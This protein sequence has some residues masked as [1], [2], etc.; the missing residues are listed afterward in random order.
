VRVTEKPHLTPQ[1]PGIGAA[2]EPARARIDSRAMMEGGAFILLKVGC[3]GPE[4]AKQA[5]IRLAILLK[6]L[7]N[8]PF[9]CQKWLARAGQDVPGLYFSEF[10]STWLI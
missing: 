9:Q 10:L 3:K 5:E 2:D 7:G 8:R 1:C 4:T 6:I